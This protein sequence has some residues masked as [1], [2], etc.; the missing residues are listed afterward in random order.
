MTP[1]QVMLRGATGLNL[2][3]QIVDRALRTRV[4]QTRAA[5]VDDYLDRMTPE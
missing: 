5:D 1:A 2:S 4:A 3:K